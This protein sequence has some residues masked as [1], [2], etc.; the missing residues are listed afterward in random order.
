[1]G[2]DVSMVMKIELGTIHK[3]DVAQDLCALT[4]LSK[5]YTNEGHW[6][7]TKKSSIIRPK[8]EL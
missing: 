4:W 5:T 2:E 7:I 1:M 8:L 3:Q 6:N